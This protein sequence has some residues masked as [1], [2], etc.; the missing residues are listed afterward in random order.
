MYQLKLE[1][2]SGP[3][4]KLLQ[5]IEERRMEI[6]EFNLAEVTA[7]FLEYLKEVEKIEPRLLADFI[8]IASQ[9]LLIKSKALLPDLALTGDEEESIKDLESR[10]QFYR[11]FKPVMTIFKE[12]WDKNQI[13]ISRPL[14]LDRPTIFYP[15]KKLKTEDLF[16][17]IKKIFSDIK[18]FKETQTIKS[19]L[20]TLEEKIEEI[21]NRLKKEKKDLNQ[22][23]FG[24]KDLTTGKSRSEIVVLFLALLHLLSSQF[25]KAEQKKQFESIMIEDNKI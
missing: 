11:R 15:D 17:A 4:D 13:S 21:I 8:I 12:L 18:E 19:S 23:K 16:N 22:T 10:L 9:L 6:T 5:L 1:Q 25:I 3:M 2:F 7:D 24:F 20:I 14:F